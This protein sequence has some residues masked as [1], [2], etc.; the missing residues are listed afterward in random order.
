MFEAVAIQRIV[1]CAS[2]YRVEHYNCGQN[3][4]FVT[5]FPYPKAGLLMNGDS[6]FC[7]SH[8]V[9]D[10]HFVEQPIRVALEN[11]R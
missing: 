4:I 11:F 9:I 2:A 10:L 8:F 1:A 3:S 7:E 5:G 6:V